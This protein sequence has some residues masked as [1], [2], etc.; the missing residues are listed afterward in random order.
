[1][2][3]LDWDWLQTFEDYYQSSVDQIFSEALDIL[4]AATDAQPAAYSI[5]EVGY[6]QRFVEQHVDAGARLREAGRS[7]RVLG[8]GITSPGNRLPEGE[9]FIRNYLVGRRFTDG[10][11]LV[12]TR[13]AWLPDDFGH[14]AQLPIVLR[15]MGLDAVAFSRVPGV[16]TLTESLHIDPPAAGSLAEALL[17]TGVGFVWRAADGSE[18]LG[19]WLSRGYS[20]EGDNLDRPFRDARDAPE[21]ETAIRRLH[22][23]LD[24][25]LP[26]S[27]TPY[28]FV[29][30]GSDFVRPKKN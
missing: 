19:H 21:S 30:L 28:V 13:Q 24:L 8:G 16:D 23:I 6:L 25:M 11:G 3:H 27:H 26:A 29:P 2:S 12:T 20:G 18:V 17:H 1:S 5:A 9:A 14:D 4:S 15:A 10:Q 22:A 7:F